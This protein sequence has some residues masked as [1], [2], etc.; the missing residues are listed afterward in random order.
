MTAPARRRLAAPTAVMLP[1]IADALSFVYLDVV[2]VVQDSTGVCALVESPR[3][4][5]RVYIPTAALSCVM[6]GPGTS[7]TQ[8]ALTTF[9][10]HGTTV[11]CVGSGGVRCY[12]GM[13]TP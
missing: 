4:E 8:P 5:E 13:L 2:R 6:L 7:I 9:A 10:R 11:L 1:R 12:S 3:G